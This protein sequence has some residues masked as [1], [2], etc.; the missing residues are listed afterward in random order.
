[1]AA[2]YDCYFPSRGVGVRVS[3]TLTMDQA[4]SPRSVQG[5]PVPPWPGARHEYVEGGKRGWCCILRDRT[6]NDFSINDSAESL[7]VSETAVRS[8]CLAPSESSAPAAILCEDFAKKI[9]QFLISISERDFPC[10]RGL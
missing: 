9:Q 1:M 6:A 7:Q 3:I 4:P 2:E 10:C 8:T 5:T